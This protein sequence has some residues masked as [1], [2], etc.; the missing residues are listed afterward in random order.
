[1]SDI[2]E[3]WVRLNEITDKYFT[4]RAELE[5][6]RGA[7]LD[8]LAYAKYVAKHQGVHDDC[9]D[10]LEQAIKDFKAL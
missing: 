3:A 6:A 2:T 5:S 10:D 8:S 1:M 4:A 7:G 9:V